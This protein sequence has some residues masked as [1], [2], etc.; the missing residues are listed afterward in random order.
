MADLKGQLEATHSDSHVKALEGQIADLKAQLA[1]ERKERQDLLDRLLAKN[2]VQ[3]IQS[4]TSTK[5]VVEMISPWGATLPEVEDEYR[6]S[7]VA[8]EKAYWI[9]QGYNEERAEAQA[10]EAYRKRHEV[11]R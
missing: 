11:M 8:E 3:P 1:D 2:N 5:T 10:E 9:G 4:E 7:W 6:K